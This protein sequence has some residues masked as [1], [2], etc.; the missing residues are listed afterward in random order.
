V[1]STE[2]TACHARRP[3]LRLTCPACTA[4]QCSDVVASAAD[5]VRSNAHNHVSAVHQLMAAA[6]AL[7]SCMSD[8]FRYAPGLKTTA[9]C[10]LPASCRTP[11]RRLAMR[12]IGISPF[13]RAA[14][15]GPAAGADR[16]RGVQDA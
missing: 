14:E 10:M 9:L 5:G 11:R 7:Y 8:G 2:R 15:Q 16:E 4:S 1:H 12:P 13:R 6:A 3:W